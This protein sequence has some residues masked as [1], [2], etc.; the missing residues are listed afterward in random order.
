MAAQEDINK[1]INEIEE[2]E[3]KID[4]T[5]Q[6]SNPEPQG[7]HDPDGVPDGVNEARPSSEPE[8]APAALSVAA[9]IQELESY[10]EI[11]APEAALESTGVDDSGPDA[12]A[13]AHHDPSPIHEIGADH[14]PSPSDEGTLSMKLT[15][16]MTLRLQYECFGQEIT[17]SFSG[18][19]FHV[20]LSDGTEFKIPVARR[21][22]HRVA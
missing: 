16:N 15:G 9:A 4:S 10:Q 18:Q 6:A 13:I 20:Q 14:S 2:L 12:D 17:V 7:F 3:G 11:E 22:L 21:H 5:H 1:I 8:K 19:V